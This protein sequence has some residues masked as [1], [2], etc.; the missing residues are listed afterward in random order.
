MKYLKCFE[1]FLITESELKHSESLKIEIEKFYKT[2][3]D[4]FEKLK[5]S[6]KENPGKFGDDGI[7]YKIK[8]L[9]GFENQDEYWKNFYQERPNNEKIQSK[10]S[11]IIY[12]KIKQQLGAVILKVS[13]ENNFSFDSKFISEFDLS[14]KSGKLTPV[15]QKYLDEASIDL[16]VN[17]F[18]DIGEKVSDEDD[19]RLVN[20]GNLG[21]YDS[22]SFINSL[23][24][25]K[26][27]G[28]WALE[29]N[30]NQKCREV[31]S[32]TIRHEL[33]HLTQYF[34]SLCISLS[35][36][37]QKESVKN[38]EN[39]DLS[40]LITQIYENNIKKIK[41]GVSKTISDISQN[42]EDNEDEKLKS[43]YKKVYNDDLDLDVKDELEKAKSLKY[44]LDDVE[45][46]PWITD[47]VNM[48]MKKLSKDSF[49]ILKNTDTEYRKKLGDEYSLEDL[50]NSITK[51]I[52]E[53]DKVVFIFKKYRKETGS[54]ILK[55]VTN[56]L[57]KLN[58]VP[59]N[60]KKY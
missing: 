28:S 34:S 44:L 16:Y 58:I 47:L 32:Q 35:E 42:K 29:L 49:Q 38:T 26:N 24:S 53:E 36:Q 7:F 12:P 19:K 3:V 51:Y 57:E 45:Y 39:V 30:L 31:V 48:Y 2:S 59:K 11:D 21:N 46:K 23:K 22:E 27:C 17:A 4:N 52:L 13:G 40:D 60:T 9:L 18:Y 8:R 41:V 20:F 55:L 56:A 43:A 50:A 6:K 54:D 1:S 5:L 37:F 33:Q 15:F 14:L 10:A 25:D